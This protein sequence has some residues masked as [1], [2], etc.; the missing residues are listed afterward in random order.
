MKLKRIVSGGALGTAIGSI[1]AAT[2]AAAVPVALVTGACGTIGALAMYYYTQSL[3]DE[4]D[5]V[6]V[7]TDRTP[8]PIDSLWVARNM[9]YYNTYEEYTFV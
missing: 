5:C 2:I 4:R 3:I 6:W 9:A 8:T 7:V 1:V